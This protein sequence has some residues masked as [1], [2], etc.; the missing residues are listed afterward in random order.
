MGVAP[1]RPLREGF[2][3][4]LLKW[5]PS[6]SPRTH[7]ASFL[8]AWVVGPEFN[9]QPVYFLKI[10]SAFVSVLLLSNC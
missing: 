10:S 2:V 5:P 4:M 6:F 3:S 1:P 8:S 7:T 9:E